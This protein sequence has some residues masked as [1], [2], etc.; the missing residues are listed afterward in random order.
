M[1]KKLKRYI[2]LALAGVLIM[3]FVVFAIGCVQ[4]K[5]V[6]QNNLPPV[7]NVVSY[8]YE[9]GMYDYDMLVT[10]Y[11]DGRKATE[12][13][14]TQVFPERISSDLSFKVYDHK[15]DG[16]F[17]WIRIYSEGRQF[18]YRVFGNGF[19][20]TFPGP[21]IVSQQTLLNNLRHAYKAKRMIPKKSK[22]KKIAMY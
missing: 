11:R 20:Q 8:S 14:V 17:Q 7:H 4:Y 15:G 6:T 1:N 19:V 3:L 21:S 12:I 22:G 10:K 16:S 9:E 5:P 2:F 13:K 18:N